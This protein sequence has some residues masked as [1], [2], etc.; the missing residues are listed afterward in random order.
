MPARP[1]APKPTYRIRNWKAY[2]DALVHRGSLTL[3]VDQAALQAWR[4]QGPARRGAQFRFSDLAIE[5]LLTLRAVYH[6]TLRATEGFARSLFELMAVD[7][8]VPDYTTL[9]RRAATVRI[10]LPKRADGPLHLILDS[11]G[12]KVYGEGEW[13]VRQH[14]YSKRRTWLKLHL[15]IDPETHEIR[16]AV[17]SEPGVTD[18]EAV[19]A[20]WA[21]EEGPVSGAGADG[22]YDRRT[23]YE[24]LERRGARAVIPPRRDAKIQRHGNTSGP[25][26]ARDENLRRI[27]RIG[28]AAWKEESGY[29]RR[30]LG[31]TAMFRMKTLFGA[32]VSCRADEQRATEVGV[33]CRAMNIM[34]HQGMPD[35]V[36]VA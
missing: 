33:R 22:A 17:V 32:G 35:T 31:E 30:S 16:A 34:T 27:R 6:L 1:A 18:E 12:L 23:V 4:Y 9:C 5:C 21:Q 24:E 3:W 8:T 13:K 14:G 20:L 2:N 19:P 10:T 15:A 26:L 29:Y 11:T 25:R 28:R 36:R 7:L